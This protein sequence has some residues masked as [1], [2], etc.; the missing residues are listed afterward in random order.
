[1]KIVQKVKV[2]N[3][4]GLHTRPAT[5]IVK[6]LQ[7]AKSYVHFTCKN[8]TVNAKSILSILMLAAKKNSSITI[9]CD[10]EDA[11]QVMEMLLKA[12]ED[13]FGEAVAT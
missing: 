13:Q 9:T 2:K 8:E 3:K 11:P 12:F 5:V 6:M 7:N 1:M 4:M 10:G